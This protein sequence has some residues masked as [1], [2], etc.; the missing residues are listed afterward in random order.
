MIKYHGYNLP[1]DLLLLTNLF[2]QL[3]GYSVL[4]LFRPVPQLIEAARKDLSPDSLREAQVDELIVLDKMWRGCGFILSRI[5]RSQ[6]PCLRRSLVLHRWCCRR[7]ID[8]TVVIGV[9]KNG[10]EL[11]GHSWLIVN[12]QPFGER[13][14]IL[15]EYIP[16][17]GD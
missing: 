10:R 4:L 5:F 3:Y 17:I 11:K 8:A 2:V 12:G 9:H 13:P 15:A 1:G 6:K 16:M 14:D 7:N